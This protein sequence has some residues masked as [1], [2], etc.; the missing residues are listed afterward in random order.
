MKFGLSTVTRGVFS[1]A[2]NYM[3]IAAAAE[4]AGFDFLA[5]SDH[6]VVPGA[7][8][9][10]YPYVPGGKFMV[11]IEG[12]CLDQLSTIAFLAGTTKTLRLLTSVMVV[13]HRHPMLTAK[14][15]ASIDVL[16]KGRLIIGA[17]AGW[18][19]EEIE[20]LGAK[21][22]ERGRYTD[23]TLAA[24]I[25]L[26]TKERGSYAGQHVKFDD[27]VF[28][29]KPVQKPYPPLWIGGE[30][31]GAI[32]RAIR[33]GT[34]WYPGNNSQTMPLDTVARLDAAN[35]AVQRQAETAGRDPSTLGLALLVQDVFEWG[36]HRITDGSARR[37]FTGTSAQMADDAAALSGIGVGHVAIR[38]G[39]ATLNECVQRIE[40]FGT[41]VISRPR[42][43]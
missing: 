18:M 33:L 37:M 9:S 41:E 3:A 6:L 1:T 39:G 32:R 28:E 4:R 15:L 43:T 30:S 24:A 11:A 31:P 12:H 22:S 35:R 2:D 40:R 7:F 26:W 42:A 19:K 21:F 36:E 20:L 34:T 10:H 17:G 27:V 29:P 23:E 14:M 16:S 13:P 25:E 8:Q 38:L 5:V